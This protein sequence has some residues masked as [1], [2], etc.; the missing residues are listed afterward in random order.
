MCARES[1][2]EP[3][4]KSEISRGCNC[5]RP[6]NVHLASPEASSLQGEH[7][8]WINTH[9]QLFILGGWL[10]VGWLLGKWGY[11]TL[12]WKRGRNQSTR[13]NDCWCLGI[14]TQSLSL[15]WL[16]MNVL[17]TILPSAPNLVNQML[18]Y[19]EIFSTK[20]CLPSK[21]VLDATW[22]PLKMSKQFRGLSSKYF[23][24]THHCTNRP[25]AS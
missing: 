8:C 13:K 10:L 1:S 17:T 25:E 4:G 15:Q 21:I 22:S 14:W 7:C 5:F 3:A 2:Q 23:R 6:I 19:P 18:N 16:Q 24:C 20:K 9:I 12:W 11:F